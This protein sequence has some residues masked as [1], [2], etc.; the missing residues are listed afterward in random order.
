MSLN[1]FTVKS[2]IDGQ[3]TDVLSFYLP[4]DATVDETVSLV[5]HMEKNAT[6][7]RGYCQAQIKAIQIAKK[8]FSEKI[9]TFDERYLALSNPEHLSKIA[10]SVVSS[11]TSASNSDVSSTRAS[12]NATLSAS[13]SSRAEPVVSSSTSASN[14]P[15]SSTRA[16]I[17]ATLERD[18]VSTSNRVDSCCKRYFK[19]FCYFTIAAAALAVSLAVRAHKN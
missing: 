10:K 9:P 11:S 7:S 18:P 19:T 1:L 3:I 13:P 5:L 15:V 2:V 16:S 14:S 4:E 17:N 8:I 6:E 12:I